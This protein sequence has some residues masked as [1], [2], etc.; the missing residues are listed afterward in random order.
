MQLHTLLELGH[1][2]TNALDFSS[3]LVA[4]DDGEETLGVTAAQSVGICVT[5]PC[6]EDLRNTGSTSRQTKLLNMGGYK[7]C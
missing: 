4:Q 3:A 2:L 5:H 1:T 6:S 7:I